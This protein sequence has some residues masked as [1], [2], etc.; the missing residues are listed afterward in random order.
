MATANSSN[1]SRKSPGKPKAKAERKPRAAS[2]GRG[3][4][5]GGSSRAGT[6]SSAQ[7]AASAARQLRSERSAAKP[8][9]LAGLAEQLAN[10]I[11]KPLGLVVLSRAG[12][13]ETLEE[14]AEHGR[15]TRSDA[16]RLV[17]ELV[18]RG[19][20]QTDELLG[21][22][23]RTLG[24]GRQQFD[25][26]SRRARKATPD[27]LIRSADRARRSIGVGPS[28][29]VLGYD[30]LTVAQVQRRLS[31]LSDPELRQVRDYERRHGNRK[32]LLVAIERAL[33]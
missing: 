13:A 31:H 4:G 19:R 12:I 25:V 6:T 15:L 30:D 21:D 16:E 24:L 11:L 7:P 17:S 18:A 8:D 20:Q 32:S 10:R 9:G 2:S 1:R 28:F 29:P 33:G 14:A 22:L 3:S 27:K 5:S 26:A 23:D